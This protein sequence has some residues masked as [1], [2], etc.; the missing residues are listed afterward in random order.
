MLRQYTTRSLRSCLQ[1]LIPRT[2]RS[3][4]HTSPIKAGGSDNSLHSCTAIC[5]ATASYAVVLG[6]RFLPDALV[7]TGS[8]SA[9]FDPTIF[10]LHAHSV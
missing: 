1:T 9:A 7:M 6:L 3:A 10:R 4:G 5:A 8:R 2:P